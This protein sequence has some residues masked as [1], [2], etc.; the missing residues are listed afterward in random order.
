MVGGGATVSRPCSYTWGS[1][2][3]ERRPERGVWVVDE[4]LPETGGVPETLS[5]KYFPV[6]HFFHNDDGDPHSGVRSVVTYVPP[7]KHVQTSTLRYLFPGVLVSSL[8]TG[9]GPLRIPPSMSV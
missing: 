2:V 7:T 9:V 1:G 5:L 6:V 8:T 4:L 3:R